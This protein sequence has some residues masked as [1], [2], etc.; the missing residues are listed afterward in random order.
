MELMVLGAL[1]TLCGV[2]IGW[3]L[4]RVPP[5]LVDDDPP[6][7]HDAAPAVR[8]PT[9][10]VTVPPA[11]TTSTTRIADEDPWWVPVDEG[12]IVE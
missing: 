7:E 4:A 8:Q 2:A 11:A 5:R 6:A 9:A 12:R 10:T 1:L 3:T